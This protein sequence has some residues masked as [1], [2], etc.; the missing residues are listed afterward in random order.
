MRSPSVRK[1][2]G[3]ISYAPDYIYIGQDAFVGLRYMAFNTG[4]LDLEDP[5]MA[6]DTLTYVTSACHFR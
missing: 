6:R 4:Y 2:E 5:L 1:L 3:V